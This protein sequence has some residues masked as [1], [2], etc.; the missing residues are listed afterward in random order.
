MQCTA[1]DVIKWQSWLTEGDSSQFD[2]NGQLPIDVTRIR[3][4]VFFTARA[5]FFQK[6]H[7]PIPPGQLPNLRRGERKRIYNRKKIKNI[8]QFFIFT[9]E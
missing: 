4:K 1:V 9:E 7:D 3:R 6:F 5:Y 8:F 2:L